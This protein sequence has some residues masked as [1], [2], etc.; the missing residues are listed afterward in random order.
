[1]SEEV[2]SFEIT[3]RCL[4]KDGRQLWVQK[5]VSLLR[6]GAGRPANVIALVTNITE[7]KRAEEQ[8]NLLMREVNHRS[9]NLLTLVQAIARQTAA[10]CPEEFLSRFE[11]RIRALARSHD[12][13]TKNEWKGVY[14][15]ELIRIQLSHFRDAIG[16]RIKLQGPGV[17]LSASAA[18]TLG[19]AFVE[20]ATNAGKYGALSN[21]TGRV[22]LSW[23][24]IKGEGCEDAFVLE[25]RESGG[26][27]VKGPSRSGFGSTI[28]QRMTEAGLNAEV[29]LNFRPEGLRWHLHCALSNIIGM[30]PRAAALPANAAA[31]RKGPAG[32]P[33][34]LVV[35]DEA[36]VALEIEEML[37]GEGFEVVGPAKKVVS[38]LE[39]LEE[40][41]CDAAILNINLGSESSEPLAR[42]LHERGI[43]FLV[44][45]GY[46]QDQR[47]A[48]FENAP[49]LV[50]PLTSELLVS[51][52]RRCIE[53]AAV[54]EA[55][56]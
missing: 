19:M 32:K 8:I 23:E 45:S 55:Q 49:F 48:G 10:R 44:L 18:Q 33:R 22:D 39:L 4:G 20:L 30:P 7:R 6:D 37:Q 15:N 25:W 42:T 14:L 51:Q 11:E 56:P 50:K 1:L 52:L 38:A 36:L 17:F 16:S 29:E 47:P 12:L 53:Q 9:K 28:I 24:I 27:P 3:N 2:N 21:E 5:H 34:I 46:S 41:G 26:P 43:P 40:R 31:N 35:E 54:H 13:L